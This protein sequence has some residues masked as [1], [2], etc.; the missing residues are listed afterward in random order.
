MW[1]YITILKSYS[2]FLIASAVLDKK[3][4]ILLYIFKYL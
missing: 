2:K 3:K 4:K 1:N